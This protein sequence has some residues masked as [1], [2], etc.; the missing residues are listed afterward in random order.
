MT[1]TKLMKLKLSMIMKKKKKLDSVYSVR[2]RKVSDV[3][4]HIFIKQTVDKAAI[5]QDKVCICISEYT[6]G[7]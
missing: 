1:T 7:Y 5:K 6:S 3:S 4:L 2:K